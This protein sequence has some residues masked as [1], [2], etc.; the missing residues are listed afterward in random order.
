[1]KPDHASELVRVVASVVSLDPDAAARAEEAVRARF[2]GQKVRIEPR[3]P[4]TV[5]MI[6]AG[7]RQRLPVREIAG[8]LGVSRATIY[9]ILGKSRRKGAVRQ[10]GP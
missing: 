3:A 1:M 8:N 9:R 10:P 6:D 2:G 4:V 5:E 7:L